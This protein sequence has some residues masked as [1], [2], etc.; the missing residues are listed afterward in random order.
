MGLSAN[1]KGLHIRTIG[2]E[3]LIKDYQGRFYIEV[4]SYVDITNA[5]HVLSEWVSQINKQ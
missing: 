3:I 2:E 5:E 4:P 1:Y